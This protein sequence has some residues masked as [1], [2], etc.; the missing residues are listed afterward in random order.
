[1]CLNIFK[2]FFK[3]DEFRSF[4]KTD[5]NEMFSIKL[6]WAKGAFLIS[7]T[8]MNCVSKNVQTSFKKNLIK[9]N[10]QFFFL[11]KKTNST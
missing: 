2:E 1:M 3:K 7:T 5:S 4:K 8:I 11:L 9:P 6:N 10:F